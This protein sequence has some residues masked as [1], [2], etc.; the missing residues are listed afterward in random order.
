MSA[1]VS[2]GT[3]DVRLSNGKAKLYLS[4]FKIKILAE[5]SHLLIEAKSSPLN[6]FPQWP[7][8]QF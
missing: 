2:L 5:T 1:T 4:L 8:K 6:I 3:T 7:L